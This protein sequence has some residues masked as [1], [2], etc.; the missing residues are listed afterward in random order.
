MANVKF[1]KKIFEKEI[2]K[3]SE[4][5]KNKI[6]MF[7]TTLEKINGDTLELE[8]FPNRPDL[9]SYYGFRR[10]FL[11][12][13]GKKTGLRKY[14][15]NPPQ[16]DYEVKIDASVKKIRPYTACAVIKGLKLNDEKI[17]DIID[18]QEKLH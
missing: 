18:L 7:G 9:L 6:A 5:M 17:K 4:E 15:I 2:G 14:K 13:L 1:N 16:K 12:F 11:S 8:V 3:L 10:A